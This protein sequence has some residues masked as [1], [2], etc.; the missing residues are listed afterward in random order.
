M[1]WAMAQKSLKASLHASLRRTFGCREEADMGLVLWFVPLALHPHVA[2]LG[3]ATQ[4]AVP[5]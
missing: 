3:S 2:P 4:V 1:F 5:G